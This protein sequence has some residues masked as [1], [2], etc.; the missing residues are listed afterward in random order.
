[1]GNTGTQDQGLSV[2]GLVIPGQGYLA[3]TTNGRRNVLAMGGEGD[4]GTVIPAGSPG[5]DVCCRYGFTI[6]STGGSPVNRFRFR[7]RNA[8]NLA[9]TTQAG[10]VTLTAFAIGTPS[11]GEA[12]WN[13]DFTAAPTPVLAA[14]GSQEVGSSEWVSPWIYPSTFSLVPNTFYGLSFGFTGPNGLPCNFSLTPGWTWAGTGSAAAAGGAG[15]PGTTAQPYTQYLDLRVEYEWNGTNQIGF[16]VGDSITSGWLNTIGGLNAIGH[17]GPD[18]AWP[19]MAA[20]RLGHHAMNAGVG[21]VTAVGPFS[22][23]APLTQLAWTRFFNPDS[24]GNGANLTGFAAVPDYIAIALG[25]N[26]AYDSFFPGL[27]TF[28]LN[29][30]D[31]VANA[32]T[33]GI[34]KAYACTATTGFNVLAGAGVPCFQAG[35]LTAFPANPMTSLSIGPLPFAILTALQYFG[36]GAGAGQPGAGNAWYGAT[37]GPWHLY[38]GTPEAAPSGGAGGGPYVISGITSGGNGVTLVLAI[39]GSPARTGGT[40]A[41]VPVMTGSEWN[42]RTINAWLRSNPPAIQSVIDFATDIECE[43]Y[44]PSAVGKPEYY[45]NAGD[46]HP[47]GPAMYGLLASRFVNGIVGN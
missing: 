41:G 19:Q 21:G 34:N 10:Q 27:P 31:I 9:N 40:L 39:S 29:Y 43:Y 7:L 18:N 38:I 17:M 13:G 22:S 33:F 24:T 3:G 26:D 32:L 12:Q 8:N 45:N 14:P 4:R 11:A 36:P 23:G 25:L 16:F 42:R 28:Q 2:G 1:M 6:P 37:G 15:V 35:V 46:I 20:L 44:Y 5:P 47:T 30:L